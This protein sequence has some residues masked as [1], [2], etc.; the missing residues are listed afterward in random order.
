[1]QVSLLQ[2]RSSALHGSAGGSQH[3]SKM[4]PQ[5]TGGSSQVS[6]ALQTRSPLQSSPVV[7][8]GWPLPPQATHSSISVSQIP[9]VQTSSAQH[10]SPIVPQAT[11]SSIS[12]SQIP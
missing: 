9:W 12:V 8:H 1:M 11:H 3:C 2:T 7:Q 5:F 10:G 4:S 6:S